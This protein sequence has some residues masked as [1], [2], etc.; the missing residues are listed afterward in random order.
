MLDKTK[1]YKTRDATETYWTFKHETVFSKPSWNAY[2][3][4]P[5]QEAWLCVGQWTEEDIERFVSDQPKPITDDDKIDF[6]IQFKNIN[7][8]NFINKQASEE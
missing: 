7:I 6:M 4:Q 2:R 8:E 1:K 3:R 5:G